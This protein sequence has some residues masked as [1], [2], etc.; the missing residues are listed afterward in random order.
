VVP[1]NISYYWYAQESDYQKVAGWGANVIR[2][3]MHYKWFEGANLTKIWAFLDQNIAWAKAN[4]LYLILDMHYAHGDIVNPGD[5]SAFW[6]TEANQTNFKNLWV[7]IAGKY[8]DEPT[9][10]GYDLLNEPSPNALADWWVLADETIDA[11][12]ATADEHIIFVETNNFA[13]K[14]PTK[15]LNDDNVV[16]SFHFYEPHDFTHQTSATEYPY[17][18]LNQNYLAGGTYTF[19]GGSAQNATWT[20]RDP[21]S[22]WSTPTDLATHGVAQFGANPNPSA[23]YWIDDIVITAREIANPSITKNISVYNGTFENGLTGW[24]AFADGTATINISHVTTENHTSS[25]N[26]CVQ[27]TNITAG[28]NSNFSHNEQSITISAF[29]IEAGYEYQIGGWTKTSVTPAWNSFRIDYHSIGKI[30]YDKEYVKA[31]INDFVWWGQTNDVPIYIGEFGAQSIAPSNQ[32][33]DWVDDV[34]KEFN[35]NN[36]HWTYHMYRDTLGTTDEENRADFGIYSE[37]VDTPIIDDN[38]IDEGIKNKVF[39]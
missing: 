26:G 19:A 7:T 31:R 20:Y 24:K 28:G 13:K 27:V 4:N 2:F 39:P 35:A 23:I 33:E 30:T 22:T 12:R 15:K 3:Y 11:I 18:L 16:Y 38:S 9:I 32:E 25:G 14:I 10:A 29:E 8:K 5:K 36:I 17:S 1:A 37:P 34:V 6:A 21:A